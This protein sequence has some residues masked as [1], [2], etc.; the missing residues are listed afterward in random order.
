M[1][2]KLTKCDV[3]V[4]CIYL[5]L[6]P[7]HSISV[8]PYFLLYFLVF[9]GTLGSYFLEGYRLSFPA[10]TNYMYAVFKHSIPML[11][12]F[13]ICMWLRPTEGGI[14]TPLSYA[15]PEQPNEVVLLQGVHTPAELLINDKVCYHSR[16][17]FSPYLSPK[18]QSRN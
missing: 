11:R 14:G 12:A 1:Y 8:C 4:Q 16:P 10:R 5:L 17:R 7:E 13:T 15:V 3:K 9:L 18:G 6:F 2:K